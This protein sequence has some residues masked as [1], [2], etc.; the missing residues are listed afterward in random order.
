MAKLKAMQA[1][2][3]GQAIG[4]GKY[5][6]YFQDERHWDYC[7]DGDKKNYLDGPERIW[8]SE[9]TSGPENTE[10]FRFTQA[11]VHCQDR[12]KPP[13]RGGWSA[14]GINNASFRTKGHEK[15]QK[16][17]NDHHDA[18]RVGHWR[19][20]AGRDGHNLEIAPL[21]ICNDRE[22]RVSAVLAALRRTEQALKEALQH[23]TANRDVVLDLLFQDFQVL[24]KAA[25]R[26]HSARKHLFHDVHADFSELRH[27]AKDLA[28]ER[29]ILLEEFQAEVSSLERQSH[30]THVLRDNALTELKE[31]RAQLVACK[32]ELIDDPKM[33]AVRLHWEGLEQLHNGLLDDREALVQQVMRCWPG[34]NFIA[35]HVMS[36]RNVLLEVVQPH[37][38]ARTADDAGD[39][40]SQ[41]FHECEAIM[42]I[43]MED[44]A[45]METMSKKMRQSRVVVNKIIK[46]DWT[47]LQKA[48]DAMRAD[49]ALMV[50]VVDNTMVDG[51][52]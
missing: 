18:A 32:K 16:I 22:S 41:S 27:R 42:N 20:A 25:H 45:H 47:C 44:S 17:S 1:A 6:R 46:E 7:R 5:A 34:L 23:L 38:K 9:T 21:D 10:V 8:R 39:H 30:D 11:T 19:K 29:K 52:W 12:A 49:C 28:V 37:L 43:V 40:K 4:G 36:D 24:E 31:N 14:R 3:K 33:V 51:K 26:L 50:A 35:Q 2:S 15:E 13:D 48:T